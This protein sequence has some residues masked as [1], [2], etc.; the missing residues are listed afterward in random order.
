LGTL[1]GRAILVAQATL[2]MALTA[3]NSWPPPGRGGA[4]ELGR[5]VPAPADEAL[6]ARLACALAR[7]GA[8]QSSSQDH[9]IL[10]GRVAEAGEMAVRAQREV[11][12]GLP[13]D[14]ALSLDA[15]EAATL[16]VSVQLPGGRRLVPVEC[17]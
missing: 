16:A 5:P 12:G 3:C 17:A 11:H 14:A 9:G 10:T 2:L 15:L 7:F 1:T 13:Q 6:A 8:V 4:A